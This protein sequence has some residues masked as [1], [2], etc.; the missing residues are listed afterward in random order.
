MLPDMSGVVDGFSQKIFKR[1]IA[2]TTVDFVETE[3]PPVDTPIWATVQVADMETK[4]AENLDFSKRYIQIHRSKNDLSINDLVVYK[5]VLYKIV[6][7]ND[8]ED[9][10]YIEAIGEQVK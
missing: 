10:G 2:T 3:L 5:T 4:Q 8:Y 1:T 7:K 9:Y 6:R